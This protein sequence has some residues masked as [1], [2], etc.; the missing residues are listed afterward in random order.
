MLFL[1]VREKSQNLSEKIFVI[2]KIKQMDLI[3]FYKEE[4]GAVSAPI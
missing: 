1:N 3:K 2:V 4:Q